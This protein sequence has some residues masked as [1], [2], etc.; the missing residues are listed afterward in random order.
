M[1]EGCLGEKMA[2]QEA[3]SIPTDSR[4][5]PPAKNGPQAKVLLPRLVVLFGGWVSQSGSTGTAEGDSV[6]SWGLSCRNRQAKPANTT[7]LLF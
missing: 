2:A 4:G 6:V 5:Y 3:L 1:G 7:F